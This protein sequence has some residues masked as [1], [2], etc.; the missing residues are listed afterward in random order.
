M[1]ASVINVQSSAEEP[2]CGWLKANASNA[3][4]VSA[5]KMLIE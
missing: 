2:R 5:I 1:S 4:A 3:K